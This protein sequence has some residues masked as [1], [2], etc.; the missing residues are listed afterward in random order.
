M[1]R[2]DL[3]EQRLQAT[4]RKHRGFPRAAATTV[5]LIKLLHKLTLDHGNELLRTH[6]LTYPEYNVLMMIDSSPDGMLN[7]SLIGDAAGEKSANVTRLTGQLADKGLVERTISPSDRRMWLLSLT[8]AGRQLI[9]TFM[10]DVSAQLRG[11]M[12]RLDAGEQAQLQHLLK[13][14]LH[15]VEDTL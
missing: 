14:L 9:E 2:F 7:P 5:R 3:T 13:Q 6:G 11:Y 4:S 10:P 1:S 8:P 15:G 12:K